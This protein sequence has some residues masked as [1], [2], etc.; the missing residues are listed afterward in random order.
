MEQDD[1]PKTSTT[2]PEAEEI[3]PDA[4]N[5]FGEGVDGFGM[6]GKDDGFGEFVDMPSVA[7]VTLE[8]GESRNEMDV[9]KVVE[10]KGTMHM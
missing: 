5:D 7:D 10:N 8:G 6:S 3:C 1:P 2:I 4:R 9:S